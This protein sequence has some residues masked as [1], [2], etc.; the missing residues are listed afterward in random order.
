MTGMPD[1]S[2]PAAGAHAPL[3]ARVGAALLAL[4]AAACGGTDARP[5]ITGFSEAQVRRVLRMSPLPPTPADPTN[6]V[7]DDP[8]AV[9]LGE[10]LF[11]DPRLSRDGDASC[12]SCHDLAL[13][14]GDGLARGRGE[15]P[16][17]RHTSSL[18]NLAGQRWFFWDGRADSLWAQACG[19]LES[20]L[21]M[22]TT[23]TDLL[24]LVAGDPT[25][26]APFE[27]LFGALPAE[28]EAERFPR[29]A[30]PVPPHD[31]ALVDAAEHAREATGHQHLSADGG[32][33]HPHQRA[34]D[35]M[36][37]EDQEVATA[38]L[39]GVA[40]ALAA[41]ER[42]LRSE[43]APLDRFVEAV[44][45][46][47]PSGGGALPEGAVRGLALFTG[48][49][50][51][52]LCHS[53]PLLSDLEFHDLGLEPAPGFEDDA[54]RHEGLDLLRV[55]EFRGDGAWSDDPEAGAARL[56]HLPDHG[57]GQREFR[58]PSLRE[59]ATHPPYMHTGALASL[60]EV[61]AFYSRGVGRRERP[62][63]AERV[64]EPL[65]LTPEQEADLVLFLRCL[66]SSAAP[67]TLSAR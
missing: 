28:L 10:R 59:V 63:P 21:E 32:F 48:E 39:V 60:E 13:G 1:H 46:G 52:H 51:C 26:R 7:A 34:W 61:V 57:H 47:D 24:H 43:T 3:G 27:A 65:H 67:P 5:S 55:A 29:A 35:R 12:A 66:T 11:R 17:A 8:R 9:A 38:A 22:A 25:L 49:A 44:R 31:P 37:A 19:V 16:L 15:V 20:P 58:T 33:I 54:G 18:W 62:V 42:T 36:A 64:I 4:L 53:G 45:A 23:R 30:R 40:K 56:A 6:A 41:Y 14:L 2:A 50:R